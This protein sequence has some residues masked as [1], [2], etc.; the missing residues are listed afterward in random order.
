MTV[1]RPSGSSD[2]ARAA[3][4]QMFRRGLAETREIWQ[5][6]RSDR[7]RILGGWMALS[8]LVALGLLGLVALVAELSL[9][10]VLA[11]GL[12]AVPGFLERT[13]VATMAAVLAANGLVLL[14]HALVCWAAYLA[15]RAVPELA[16]RLTGIHR[17]I[18]ERAGSSAMAIVTAL[19][20]YSLGQQVWVLGQGL[21]QI[22]VGAGSSTLGVLSRLAPHAVVEL[23]AVFLPLAACLLLGRQRRWNTLL[24]AAALSSLAALP[25]LLLASVWEGWVAPGLFRSAVVAS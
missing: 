6:W 3:Q 2:A 21:A 22:A 5:V 15:R 14:L 10:R 1:A 12:V 17:W 7:F 4:Q 20:L 25:L 24:A 11:Q 23:T 19:V 13:P 16:P 9:D 8:L 18:H